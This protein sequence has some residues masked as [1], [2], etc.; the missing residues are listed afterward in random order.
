MR[1]STTRRHCES[2][3]PV[4]RVARPWI[5]AFAGM[6][7]FLAGCAVGP[8][9]RRPD[10]PVAPAFHAQDAAYAATEPTADFWRGFDDPLLTQLVE[11]AL[12]ANHDLR[13]ALARLDQARALA[14]LSRHDLLPTVT[15]GAGYT[16][17]RASQDQAP[18][19]PREQRDGEFYDAGFDAF[20][21]L[22][23]FGRVRRGVEASRAEADAAAADL[24]ALQ[25]SLAAEVAR[26]YFELRGLQ[27]QLRVARGNAENQA[28]TL[29]L[30]QARLDA[31]RGTEFDVAR[32]R[33]Q[34]E[35]TRSRI[36]ALEAASLAAAHRLAVLNG[37]EPGALLGELAAPAPLPAAPDRIAVGAPAELLRRR[38]DV[39][40]AERRLASATARV[41]LATADLFPRVTF[42]GTLGASAADLGDL[43]TRDS[44]AYAF[45][46]AIGWAFLD[47]GRVRSRI[48]ASESGAAANLALYEGA[49]L[50]ALEESENALAGFARSQRE[51]RHLAESASASTRAAQL[52]RLRFDGGAADFLHVL[53][54]ERSQLESEDRLAQSRT[55]TA[56]ALVAVYKAVAGGWPDRAAGVASR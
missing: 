25:V 36:P 9:Y 56:T 41:G 4:S 11:G 55:R 30:T 7:L 40:A 22:D 45:G 6:T 46:P 44:Q 19:V 13:A 23:L 10:T 53:D 33:G 28:A 54:A 42:N 35:F 16:E 3:G 39:Q 47:L 51:G 43:F 20:W 15:A 12:A 34:L 31:G 50:R 38:P 29:A 48:V 14:R 2:G 32:A 27:E 1:N 37:R 26:T 5:P 18:G 17:T 24:R 8:D 52:A 21:E 49:V